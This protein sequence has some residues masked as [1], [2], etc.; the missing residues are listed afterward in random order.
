VP[1]TEDGPTATLQRPYFIYLFNKHTYWI[2]ETCLTI[3]IFFS[4]HKTVCYNLNVLLWGQGVNDGCSSFDPQ[5]SSLDKCEIF[6]KYHSH[7]KQQI[8]TLT[9]T[10]WNLT[11]TIAERSMM[12]RTVCMSISNVVRHK[13][14]TSWCRQLF[15]WNTTAWLINYS[16]SKCLWQMSVHNI[17]MM[18]TV[19]F[20]G[21]MWHI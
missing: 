13:I 11:R 19:N 21:Y 18:D 20:F 8:A 6:H 1:Y 12:I 5:F 17:I 3:S 14:S 16:L 9:T 7:H 10:I 4:L 15:T 2:F